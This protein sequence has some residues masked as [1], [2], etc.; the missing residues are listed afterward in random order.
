MTIKR[1]YSR[2]EID[3]FVITNEITKQYPHMN[4]EELK[5]S[6]LSTAE[7]EKSIYFQL[8]VDAEGP[9]D[10]PIFVY[11]SGTVGN[12]K[13]FKYNILES[14]KMFALYFE[15]IEN[16]YITEIGENAF[17]GLPIT[18]IVLSEHIKKI[19]KA[20]FCDCKYLDSVIMPDGI[21]RIEENAF[22]N[23]T[24]LKRI[25]LPGSLKYI[26]NNAFD[27]CGDIEIIQS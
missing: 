13:D 18:H 24:A 6:E 11:G 23:C 5:P 10:E 1:M 12:Y 3:N 16:E 17:S 25:V 4:Y 21:E 26:A 14:K 27:N 7:N 20:A 19:G 15:D 2:E 22:K 9:D 8:N